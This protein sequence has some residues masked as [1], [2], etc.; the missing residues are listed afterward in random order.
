M[1]D[2]KRRSE[3]E[4]GTD[5]KCDVD[6]ASH[7]E[8]Q[9][10]DGECSN[11]EISHGAT[12]G[13]RSSSS[14]RSRGKREGSKRK[15]SGRWTSCARPSRSRRKLEQKRVVQIGA[16]QHSRHGRCRRMPNPGQR[17]CGTRA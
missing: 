11:G 9:G 10:A 2:E 13:K 15:R 3:N 12:T 1:R 4:R 7:G 17:F 14:G 6:S 8:R 5:G 16:V